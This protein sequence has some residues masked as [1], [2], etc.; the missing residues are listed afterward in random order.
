[1]HEIVTELHIPATPDRV[2]E[3]MRDLAAWPTWNPNVARIDG[4]GAVGERLALYLS[5]GPGK[6]S[7]RVAATITR[8]DPGFGVEWRGGFPGVPALL[9]I[10]HYFR[11]EPDGEGTRFIHGERFEGLL[12]RIFWPLIEP[13]VSPNYEK[14]N[15]GLLRAVTSRVRDEAGSRSPR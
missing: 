15:Q 11:I 13:Q 14:T 4:R 3:V 8:F 6:R 10:H 12:A 9:D 1:M 5:R 2:F 7:I